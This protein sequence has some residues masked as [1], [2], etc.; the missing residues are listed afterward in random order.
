MAS[1]KRS[2]TLKNAV[3]AGPEKVVAVAKKARRGRSNVP[4]GAMMDP[5][6]NVNP[7]PTHPMIENTERAE[8]NRPVS[9]GPG[10]HRGDRRDM[11][12]TYTGTRK[13]AS[14]GSNPRPSAKTRKR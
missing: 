13:H 2:S 10:R 5:N 7:T 8:S 9:A 12:P 11:S 1:A 14:R 6:D 3:T 4:P